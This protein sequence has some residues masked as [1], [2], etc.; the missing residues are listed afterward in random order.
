[1][2]VLRDPSAG[3]VV[4]VFLLAENRLLREALV[5]LLSKRGDIR[6]VGSGAHSANVLEQVLAA[7][8]NIVVLDSVSKALS[9][10][11][12]VRRLCEARPQIGV[13][14][15]GMETDEG[16]FLRLVHA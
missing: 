11:R 14:M 12:L 15:V 6:V 8:P 13:V 1:M 2:A 3:I 9:N 5:R 16:V 7:Q 10:D 4:P